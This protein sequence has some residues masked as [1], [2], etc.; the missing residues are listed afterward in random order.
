MTRAAA[1]TRVSHDGG[2]WPS[3]SNDGTV[4]F[5]RRIH[6][7]PDLRVV[8]DWFSELAVHGATHARLPRVGPGG[9]PI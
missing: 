9:R 4:Y 8:L 7:R 5:S 1:A 2:A 3:W 6:G